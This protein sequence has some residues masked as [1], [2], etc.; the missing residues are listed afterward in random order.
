MEPDGTSPKFPAPG[1]HGPA[2]PEDWQR[3]LRDNLLRAGEALARGLG[4][5]IERAADDIRQAMAQAR[6]NRHERRA[7]RHRLKELDRAARRR[8]KHEDRLRRIAEK[9]EL[10]RA[11]REAKLARTTPGDARR[12]GFVAAAL[13]AVGLATGQLWLL[14]IA[15][16]LGVRSS[17]ISTYHREKALQRQAAPPVAAPV[18]PPVAAPVPVAAAPVAAPAPVAAAPAPPPADP[19]DTR[20]DQLCDRLQTELKASPENVRAFLGGRPEETV[21][22]LRRTCHDLLRRERGLRAEA[23]PAERE[24]LDREHA[25]LAARIRDETDDVVKGRLLSALAAIEEQ[26]E[27]R[28]VLLRNANRLD[29]EHTR[30]VWTLESLLAQMVRLRTSGAD[31]AAA[32]LGSS[33]GQLKDS[34]S[35]LSDALEEVNGPPPAAPLKDAVAP[36]ADDAGA[37]PRPGEREHV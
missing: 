25:T 17:R 7:E 30:L 14:F 32:G 9:E 15:F 36:S 5:E 33:V 13:A 22:T 29:A 23:S 27:H 2:R 21:E 31:P 6:M 16:A 34:L 4:P 12:Y 20:I 28:Q 1:S 37:A 24:R 19:R 3:D 8:L 18:T 10:K 26:R 11:K 35:A